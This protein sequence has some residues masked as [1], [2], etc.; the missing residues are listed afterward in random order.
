M[1]DRKWT[2]IAVANIVGIGFLGLFA[3]SQGRSTSQLADF[4]L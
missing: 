4:G 3:R 2:V 1:V